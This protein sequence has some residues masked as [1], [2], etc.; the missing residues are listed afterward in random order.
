[1]VSIFTFFSSTNFSFSD[2]GAAIF[3]PRRQNPVYRIFYEFYRICMVYRI[4]YEFY[5][6][7]M[8]YRIFYEFYRISMGLLA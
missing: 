4:F 2:V 6:I 3:P 8:V 1:M 5:R 7:C